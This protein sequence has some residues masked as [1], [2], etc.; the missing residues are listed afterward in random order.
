MKIER[1]KENEKRRKGRR[2]SS[3]AAVVAV[4]E[5][6]DIIVSLHGTRAAGADEA[7][8]MP[9]LV[10]SIEVLAGEEL[11]ATSTMGHEEL[12]VIFI[13]I[14]FVLVS[15]KA[16]LE[17]ALAVETDKAI[18]MEGAADRLQFLTEDV[19]VASGTDAVV[20]GFSC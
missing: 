9:A 4:R 20:W 12:L 10:E 18:R 2:S 1:I 17:F 8:A 13:A 6:T 16:S 19:L 5:A 3:V 7:L 11:L 15:A 14:G